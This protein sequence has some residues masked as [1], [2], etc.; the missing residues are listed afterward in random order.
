MKNSLIVGSALLL[1]SLCMSAACDDN[2]KKKE[3]DVTIDAPGVDVKVDGLGAAG[4]A[5]ADSDSE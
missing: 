5:A 3:D 1:G 4:A 2:D